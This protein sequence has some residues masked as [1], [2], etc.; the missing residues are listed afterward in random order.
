MRLKNAVLPR[1]IT[2]FNVEQLIEKTQMFFQRKCNAIVDRVKLHRRIQRK[3]EAVQEYAERLKRIATNCSFKAG[4][5]EDRLRD[6]F[7]A[8]LKD[9]SIL[10]KMYEKEDLLTQPLD[11]VILLAKALEGARDSVMATHEATTESQGKVCHLH[12]RKYVNMHHWAQIEKELERNVKNGVLEPVNIA[13]CAFSTVNIV[14]PNDDI[15]IC[16]DFKPLNRIM[17]VDQYPIPIPA[18]MF[19]SLAGGKMFSKIDLKDAY[20]QLRVD[21]E[22]QKW[23][24][25][26]THKELFKYRRLPFGISSAPAIFQR[27][28]AKVLEGVRGICIYMDDIL[29]SG[30]DEQVHMQN[31]SQVFQK[32]QQHGF[33]IRRDKCSFCQPSVQYLGHIID[34]SGI[35]VSNERVKA[36]QLMKAPKDQSELRS[37]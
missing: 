8:G 24:V 14:K 26:N 7:V 12:E 6:I 34:R 30:K 29:I 5:Y 37:F 23:L 20:N 9:D 1:E 36:I 16:C 21:E 11:K 15:R 19:S 33:R 4:E 10:Q 3:E 27:T 28:I 32:L 35:R 2:D 13:L 18:E 25:I 22:S 31:L 17:V